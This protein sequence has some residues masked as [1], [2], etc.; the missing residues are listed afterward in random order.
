MDNPASLY[1]R[2]SFH[3]LNMQ[4]IADKKKRFRFV[5]SKTPGS[6]HDS[7][8]WAVS[9]MAT[10]MNEM[11]LPVHYFI[12]SDD[13]HAASEQLIVPFPVR[14]LPDDMKG[15]LCIVH[16]CYYVLLYTTN[17]NSTPKP[18]ANVKNKNK[19]KSKNT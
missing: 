19:N 14:G 9:R 1:N 15:A 8:A 13:A 2:K 6:T 7:V 17:S 3:A 11:K 10:L 12:V 18:H 5:S 4:T 16:Y